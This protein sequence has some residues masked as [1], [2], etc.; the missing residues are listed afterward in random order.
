MIILLL[1]LQIQ[2]KTSNLSGDY[3]NMG[4]L[5]VLYTL[6]GI[7]LGLI[8]SVPLLLQARKITYAQQAVFSFAYWPFRCVLCKFMQIMCYSMKLLWAPIVDSVYWSRIGRRKSWLV[9]T[10]YL[11]GIFMMVFSFYAQDIIGESMLIDQGAP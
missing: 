9:P 10:Q 5:L 8:A 3:G 7:P 4:V 11:I 1:F 2:D 6:Q